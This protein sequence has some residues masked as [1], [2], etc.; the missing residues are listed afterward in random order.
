MF[1]DI[2]MFPIKIT[3]YCLLAY[4]AFMAFAFGVTI[5]WSVGTLAVMAVSA[6]FGHPF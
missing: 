2:L 5:L 3:I 6:L 4:L 1:L